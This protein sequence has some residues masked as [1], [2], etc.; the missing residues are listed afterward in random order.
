[1]SIAEAPPMAIMLDGENPP[2]LYTP[3]QP[4]KPKPQQAPQEVVDSFWTAFKTQTPGKVFTVLPDNY[5]VKEAAAARPIGAVSGTTTTRSFEQ[6][7]DA[8]RE[9][10]QKISKECRRVNQKYRDTHFDVEYDL[11]ASVPGNR[12]CLDGL[13]EN[14]E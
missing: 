6:A 3:A 13:N 9:K 12:F 1:M 11:R 10:V 7:A 2:G 4:K 5:Y 8:C 14:I